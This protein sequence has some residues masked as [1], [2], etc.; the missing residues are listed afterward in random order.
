[1]LYFVGLIHRFFSEQASS[2][3]AKPT[4]VFRDNHKGS[5][6]ISRLK[7]FPARNLSHPKQ[8]PEMLQ[9]LVL[10]LFFLDYELSLHSPQKWSW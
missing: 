9:M 10:Q 5:E 6:I 2:T 8:H 1:M 4:T 3:L 7:S